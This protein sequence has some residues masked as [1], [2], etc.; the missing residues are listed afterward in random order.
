V[1]NPRND[2]RAK[3]DRRTGFSAVLTQGGKPVDLAGKTVQFGIFIGTEELLAYTST[4]V[5]VHPTRAFVVN[6]SRNS[7]IAN[8][9]NV[10]S[11]MEVVLA[12]SGGGLPSGLTA[13]VRYYA[14]D[15][16]PNSFRL[17][18]WLSGPVVSITSAGTGT[19]TFYIVGSVTY[20]I[21]AGV[22]DLPDRYDERWTVTEGGL[23][24]TFPPTG[25]PGRVLEVTTA[26]VVADAE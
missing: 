18:E 10:E 11:G 26:G 19:H 15:V 12:N 17:R 8:G 14:C 1:S 3:G 21:A 5:T 22:T 2:I 23:V 24:D 13:G 25:T 7:I 6:T 20:A 4:G 16:E 9:H